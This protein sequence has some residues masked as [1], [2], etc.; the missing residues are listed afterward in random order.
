MSVRAC[1]AGFTNLT[2]MLRTCE[3]KQ[4]ANKLQPCCGVGLMV[5]RCSAGE[6][7]EEGG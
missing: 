4:V 7:E 1:D 3:V 6:G 2:V 5:S